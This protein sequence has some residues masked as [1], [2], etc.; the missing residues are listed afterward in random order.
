MESERSV[1]A[2]AGSS[3][4]ESAEIRLSSRIESSDLILTGAVGEPCIESRWPLVTN[5]RSKS[6]PGRPIRWAED[7]LLSIELAR[8]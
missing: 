8:R 6:T 4:M 5:I 1:F 7:R 2:I 3:R